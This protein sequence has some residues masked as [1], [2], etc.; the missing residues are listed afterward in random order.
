MIFYDNLRSKQKLALG[1]EIR[2]RVYYDNFIN[3]LISM[4]EYKNLPDTMESRFIEISLIQNGTV[5]IAKIDNQLYS[6]VA[7]PCGNVNAY[8]LGTEINGAT[9]IGTFSGKIGK[10]CV[11]G[12]NNAIGS[13]DIMIDWLTHMLEQTDLSM[14]YNV[15]Y[16]RYKPIPIAKSQVQK[17]Q[18][19]ELLKNVDSDTLE[20]IAS[21]NVLSEFGDSNTD[22]QVV[23]LTDVRYIDKL[24]YLSLYHD[25]LLNRFYKMYGQSP[26]AINKQAQVNDSELH[27]N[28]SISF[29]IPLQRLEFR[30]KMVEEINKIFGTNI[31]VCFS[32]SWNVERTK[33]NES[34]DETK[35]TEDTEDT[36]ETEEGGEKDE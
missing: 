35:D 34:A 14:E 7:S 17:K 27:G 33:F 5:G 19:D 30:K 11:L 4:F 15:K 10:D 3:V 24:Q 2:E 20:S 9:P 21:E 22:L 31:E 1:K 28:D 36:E 18:I 16:A 25:D 29:L 8:G 26:Q 12:W 23:N 6:F 13:P 32:E